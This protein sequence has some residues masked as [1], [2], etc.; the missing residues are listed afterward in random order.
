MTLA[1]PAA[2]LS[3]TPGWLPLFYFFFFL[4]RFFFFFISSLTHRPSL[5]PAP[6]MTSFFHAVVTVCSKVAAVRCKRA[7]GASASSL[8]C[9]RA[10]D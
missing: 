10:M 2:P 1:S 5:L 7:S 6:A 8:F 9:L 4:L 3:T